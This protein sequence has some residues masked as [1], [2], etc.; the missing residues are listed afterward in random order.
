MLKYLDIST[1]KDTWREKWKKYI[2]QKWT[3][4]TENNIISEI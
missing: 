4:R 3:S 2:K 1:N